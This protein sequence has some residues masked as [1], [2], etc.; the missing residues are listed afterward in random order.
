MKKFVSIIVIA[1]FAILAITDS[2]C[3]FFANAIG[4]YAERPSRLILVAVIGVLGGVALLVPDVALRQRKL[5]R[6]RATRG[7]G[8]RREMQC[9]QRAVVLR[10]L[11]VDRRQ[12]DRR[13]RDD[14]P[15][16]KNP[17][18]GRADDH[19]LLHQPE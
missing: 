10:A 6:G 3:D 16:L 13:Q 1:A 11:R 9:P 15:N 19:A 8:R 18:C 2:V 12:Q 17:G 7:I 14:R 5:G 4:Y